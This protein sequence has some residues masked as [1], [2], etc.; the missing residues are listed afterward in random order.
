[1]SRL[2]SNLKMHQIL[3]GRVKEQLRA[4]EYIIS[5]DGM[6]IRVVDRTNSNFKEGHLVRLVVT[7]VRPPQFRLA[8]SQSKSTSF[9][10]SV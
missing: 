7:G 10:R 8:S 6:L 2:F 3:Q 9:N 1:M 5:V 4:G